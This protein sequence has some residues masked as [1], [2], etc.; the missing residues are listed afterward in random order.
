[1]AM[2]SLSYIDM[3]LLLLDFIRSSR[4]GNWALHLS[5]IRQML[6]WMFAY[7]RVNYCRYMS[8]YWCEMMALEDSHPTAHEELS[9]G[10]FCVQRSATSTFTQVSVDQCIE[11]TMNRHSKLKGEGKIGFSH[12]P[13]AVQKW[14]V[15][16]HQ[17]AEITEKC[18]A[19]AGA[20][21]PTN[22]A[23]HK[24]SQ[25]GRVKHDEAMVQSVQSTLA[26][27]PN[28]FVG[29]LDAEESE[30]LSN[31]SSGVVATDSVTTDLLNAQA[32]GEGKFMEF[33]NQR[34]TAS[35]HRVNFYDRL[36]LQKLKTFSSLATKKSVKVGGKEV[37][38]RADSKL[39][40]RLLVVAQ[41]RAMDIPTVLSYE[42]GPL[43]W[44][45]AM[46]DGGL[47]KTTKTKL[48]GLLESGVP[49]AEQVPQD[50]AWIVDGM[51]T[52]QCI[53]T[54][55]ETFADLAA[56][57]Y[58]IATGPFLTG[59][60]RVDF[61]VDQYPAIS[62]KGRERASRAEMGTLKVNI[63]HRL[64][65]C[66]KQWKK[67]LAVG[68]NKQSLQI[69]LCTEWQR[70][71][72]AARL[73]GRF[74][75]V[76]CETNCTRLTST[77]GK[78]VMAEDV[79]DLCCSHEEAD[80]RLLLHA[81]HAAH[82]GSSNIV[83]RSPDTDVPV[84]A[85]TMSRHIPAQLF[86]RTGTKA[87]TRFVCIGAIRAKEGDAVCRSLPA[88]HSL[89][90]CD[91]TS[92]FKRR[93]KAHGLNIVRSSEAMAAGLSLLG[94]NF[95]VSDD[96][97]K[98]C[99]TFVCQLYGSKTHTN[100]NDLRYH[101]FASKAAQGDQ[102]PPTRDALKLHIQR[103][104]YQAA[105]WRRSLEANPDVPSPVGRG[106]RTGEDGM[107]EVKWMEQS[108]APDQL[109]IL[110]NCRCKKGCE[111]A[112]CSCVRSTLHCTD[113][114]ACSVNCSNGGSEADD[115]SEPTDIA[116]DD[117]GPEELDPAWSTRSISTY[118]LRS[119]IYDSLDGIQGFLAHHC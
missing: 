50:A 7:D 71:E 56:T 90:G 108:P 76:T 24:E 87:R 2:F 113:A 105:I 92:A 14:A 28:P 53:N 109:I 103:A 3:V 65:K 77:D 88:L 70:P 89:T 81:A 35:E 98:L 66:P 74:F 13:G 118:T 62:I 72:Y 26:T 17:R 110:V 68:S 9:R 20:V 83:I 34:L 29:E 31:I 99:E 21:G 80:T 51:A 114:C 46:L 57:V 75:F 55:P 107:L 52:L 37:T 22:V 36:P 86:F 5:S 60:V 42:L 85:C 49:P 104:N 16:S 38:V 48:F 94:E 101:L 1:M 95:D 4:Q 45:L 97:M 32:I 112:R 33:Y 119:L 73:H 43:P 44:S 6:P 30:V 82:T 47:C 96:L 64:Q 117:S 106:W 93:G 116:S 39:F 15:N 8:V 100:V 115:G 67:Y 25:A 79:A 91:S 18:K 78:V 54:V 11:Q 84:L 63:Q 41:V 111:T 69:F 27:L 61:V 40:A 12:K 23:S 10:E 58:N 102:L 59:A 19:M